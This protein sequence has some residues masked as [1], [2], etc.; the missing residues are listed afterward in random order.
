MFRKNL[1]LLSSFLRLERKCSELGPPLITKAGS[2]PA[3]FIIFIGMLL[4]PVAFLLLKSYIMS[5]IV[6]FVH[7]LI[8]IDSL[9]GFFKKGLKHL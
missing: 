7:G 4:G 3:N 6:S 9:N 5:M 2:A 8:E 1:P